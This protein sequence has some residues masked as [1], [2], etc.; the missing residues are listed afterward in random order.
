MSV[1]ENKAIARRLYEDV[2]NQ[3]NLD[4]ANELLAPTYVAHDP[5]TSGRPNGIEGEQQTASLAT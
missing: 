5:G 2:W 1:Q 3:G 4:V